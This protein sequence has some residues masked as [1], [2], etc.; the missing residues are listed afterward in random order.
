METKEGITVTSIEHLILTAARGGYFLDCYPAEELPH[1]GRCRWV[2]ESVHR[3]IM[4]LFGRSSRMPS[5]IQI[6]I[7]DNWAYKCCVTLNKTRRIELRLDN[8]ETAP[9]YLAYAYDVEKRRLR[10]YR[11]R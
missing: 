8:P 10:R 5:G 9:N 2:K 1:G 3:K 11:W 6:S 4:T 7:S